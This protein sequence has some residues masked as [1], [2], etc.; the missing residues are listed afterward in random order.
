[1]HINTFIDILFAIDIIISF[2]TT[3][4]CPDT[5]NEIV[6]DLNIAINYFLGRFI[7]DLVSTIPFD[8]IE[9]IKGDQNVELNLNS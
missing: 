1:M 6:E 2:R 5:G 4:Q 7:I 8:K 3:Y 9:S